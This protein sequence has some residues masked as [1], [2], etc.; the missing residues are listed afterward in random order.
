M[1]RRRFKDKMHF[2]RKNSRPMQ[3]IYKRDVHIY[4]ME[5]DEI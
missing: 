5:L 1:D 4:G 2:I 3:I